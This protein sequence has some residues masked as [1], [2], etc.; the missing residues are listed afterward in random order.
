MSE[1]GSA[2]S[3]VKPPLWVNA[4]I[5]F[6]CPLHCLFCYNPVDYAHSGPELTTDE[7]VTALR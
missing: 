5:T 4:E 6:R 3:N 2:P 1:A 7:W